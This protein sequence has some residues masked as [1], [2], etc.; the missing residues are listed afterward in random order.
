VVLNKE[1][2]S[3]GAQTFCKRR[4]S[5]EQDLLVEPLYCSADQIRWT[6]N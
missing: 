2:W 4:K 6:I 5:A 3:P 1:V